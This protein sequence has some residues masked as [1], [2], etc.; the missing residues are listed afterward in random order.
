[1]SGADVRNWKEL[2]KTSNA[3][4]WSMKICTLLQFEDLYEYIEPEFVLPAFTDAKYEVKMKGMKKARAMLIMRLTAIDHKTIIEGSSQA[5]DLWAGLKGWAL[6]LNMA[7]L[8][9]VS[10]HFTLKWSR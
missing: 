4:G 10:N 7:E 1:M 6:Q 5:N 2:L 8:S 3:D 9:A